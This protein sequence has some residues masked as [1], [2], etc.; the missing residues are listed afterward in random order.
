[1]P[2]SFSKTA[3]LADL[4]QRKTAIQKEKTRLQNEL[5]IINVLLETRKKKRLNGVKPND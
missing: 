2:E 1:M 3:T 5:V 4:R